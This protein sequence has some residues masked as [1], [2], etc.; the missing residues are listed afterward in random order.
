[1]I[2]P[3]V[4]AAGA[5]LTNAFIFGVSWWFFRKLQSYGLH[6]MW[7]TTFIYILALC[8]LQVLQPRAWRSLFSHPEL[9]WLMVAS[10][11]TN[12]GFNWAVTTGD[13]VRVVLLFYL[14]PAWVVLVAWMVLGERPTVRAIGCLVLALVGIVIVLKTPTAPWPVPESV[15]DWMALMGGLSFAVTNVL[16]RKNREVPQEAKLLGMFVGG[17]VMAALA[18]TFGMW[19]G[20]V[21]ELP[22]LDFVWL[23]WAVLVAIAFLFGNLAL[24]FGAARLSSSTTSLIMLFEVVFASGSSV[25]LGAGEMSLRTLLGATLILSA[26]LLS[27][28]G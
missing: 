19:Q 13:V 6:P 3:R 22:Q 5:L 15:A 1:M 9:I 16:L 4:F 12:I 10:G 27:L 7:A 23:G 26:S 28:A 8:I 20:F 14:M 11:F 2:S 24:Q 25:V 17:G 21:S 18:A